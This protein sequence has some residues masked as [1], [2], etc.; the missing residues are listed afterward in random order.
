QPVQ[1]AFNVLIPCFLIL[2]IWKPSKRKLFKIIKWD[3]MAR[4]L[5]IRAKF[6][7]SMKYF[8]LR[9]RKFVMQ[10]NW[11]VPLMSKQT[12]EWVFTPLMGR[13]LIFRFSR[14]LAEYW[15]WQKQRVFTMAIYK[16]EEL[17]YDQCSKAGN[18]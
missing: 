9:R 1:Q 3:L 18:S 11:F 13:W 8:H 6:N 7:L 10:K 4:V 16:E 14:M 12:Q 5:L 15:I 17:F 2:T